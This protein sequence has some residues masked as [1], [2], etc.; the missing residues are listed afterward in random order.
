[1]NFASLDELRARGT[2]LLARGPVALVFVEDP[3]EI[4]STV[5]HH[6]GLGFCA[7]IVFLP[8]ALAVPEEAPETAHFV[9]YDTH[10]PEAVP[11]AVNTLAAAAPGTWA[12]KSVIA[13]QFLHLCPCWFSSA[14]THFVVS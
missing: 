11:R 12:V 9:R 2:A 7:V 3:V 14:L 4:V 8:G 10:A 5:T 1:M 13:S 6:T